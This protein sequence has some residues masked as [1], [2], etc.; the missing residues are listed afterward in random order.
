MIAGID[1]FNTGTF[2]L[3]RVLATIFEITSGSAS[4]G[5]AFTQNVW[6]V[7][8]STHMLAFGISAGFGTT[9]QFI[10]WYGPSPTGRNIALCDDASALFSL[11]RDGILFYGGASANSD[12]VQK[13]FSYAFTPS[14]VNGT[15]YQAGTILTVFPLYGST[16]VSLDADTGGSAFGDSGYTWEAKWQYSPDRSTWT[17]IAGASVGG[18]V[19]GARSTHSAGTNATGTKTGLTTGA[20]AYFRMVVRRTAGTG[21]SFNN[22]VGGT[23]E[24]QAL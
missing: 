4:E 12:Y 10:L 16:S 23:A 6:R 18:G 17:D 9:G 21:G 22:K 11:R 15:W 7:W 5:T 20:A 19:V 8:S 1:L 14:T 2:S 24:A 3:F 13:S